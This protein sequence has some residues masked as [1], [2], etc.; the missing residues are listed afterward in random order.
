M[1]LR[2]LIGSRNSNEHRRLSIMKRPD[3][4][5]TLCHPPS[6]GCTVVT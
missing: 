1:C 4:A 6:G 3:S 2:F 5:I